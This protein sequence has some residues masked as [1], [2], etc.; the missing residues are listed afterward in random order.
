VREHKQVAV[1]EA[2]SGGFVA[3]VAADDFAVELEHISQDAGGVRSDRPD[4]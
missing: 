3:T 4:A 2:G 1:V